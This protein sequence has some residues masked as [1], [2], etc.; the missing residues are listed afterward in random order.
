M[1]NIEKCSL[2]YIIKYDNNKLL[3]KFTNVK[4]KVSETSNGLDYRSEIV[5]I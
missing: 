5:L 2:I 1:A 3:H 4:A